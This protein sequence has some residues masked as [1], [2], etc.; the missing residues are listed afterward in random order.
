M[1]KDRPVNLINSFNLIFNQQLDE[2]MHERDEWKRWKSAWKGEW[3]RRMSEEERDEWNEWFERTRET[4]KRWSWKDER[5]EW[6]MDMKER[7]RQTTERINHRMTMKSFVHTS[8]EGLIN[9]P[10]LKLCKHWIFTLAIRFDVFYLVR[11]SH[12]VTCSFIRSF[13]HSIA[14]SVVASNKTIKAYPIYVLY[15]YA[16]FTTPLKTR[17]M[18]KRRDE[19]KIKMNI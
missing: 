7:K 12:S 3:K 13:I 11:T 10:L 19:K 8:V 9:E 15:M 18:R 14:H 1:E 2:W 5:A 17:C 6:T 16:Y 4:V